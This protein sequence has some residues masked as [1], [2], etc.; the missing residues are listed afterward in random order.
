MSGKPAQGLPLLRQAAALAPADPEVRLQIALA[1]E[2]AGR[3]GEALR[4]LSESLARGLPLSRVTESNYLKQL[5]KDP[6]FTKLAVQYQTK[7]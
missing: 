5:V 6:A 4:F 3:R 2:S 1:H 7:P